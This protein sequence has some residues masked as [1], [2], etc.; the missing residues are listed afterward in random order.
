MKCIFCN[1]K[2]SKVIDSRY[3]EENNTIRRRREC[4]NHECLKRFTTYEKVE[5]L[6]ILVIKKDGSRQVFDSNKI[7]QGLIKACEKRPVTIKQVE[8]IVNEIE[9][10]VQSSLKQEI[11]SSEIGERVMAY[12]KEIDEVSYIR[13]ASVYRKFTDITH[14]KSFINEIDS[15][16]ESK[17]KQI[18]EEK[19]KDSEKE[20]E[21]KNEE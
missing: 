3:V 9:K 16:I 11:K 5:T 2:D 13:F 14:F 19:E 10:Y 21:N 20:S 6:P 7:K 15:L 12:L 1:Y 4:L 18:K 8:E 17:R